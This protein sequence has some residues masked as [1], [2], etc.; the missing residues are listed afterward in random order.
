MKRRMHTECGD[1]QGL[2]HVGDNEASAK[3]FGNGNVWRR[4]S[5]D[6]TQKKANV[7][8]RESMKCARP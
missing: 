2:D 6:V 5:S 8:Q 1:S 7:A 3:N 4:L